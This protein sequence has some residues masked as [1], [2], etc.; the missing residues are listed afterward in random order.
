MPFHG[1]VM[2]SP[3][4]LA[5]FCPPSI[6]L[7]DGLVPVLQIID[8]LICLKDNPEH[9]V[10]PSKGV[11][12]CVEEMVLQSWTKILALTTNFTGK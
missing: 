12:L 9:K 2:V 5:H 7:A 4:L 1:K 6:L 8:E 3:A 11:N 10:D